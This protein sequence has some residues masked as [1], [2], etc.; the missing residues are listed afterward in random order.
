MITAL[1]FY[2]VAKADNT[3]VKGYTAMLLR[4]HVRRAL[5]NPACMFT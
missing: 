2:G 1:I 3:D 5:Q 4:S